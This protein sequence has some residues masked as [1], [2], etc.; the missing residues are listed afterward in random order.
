MY[1]VLD[2]CGFCDIAFA[3]INV[4]RSDLL[5][6]RPSLCSCASPEPRASK[7]YTVAL[8][9]A[10]HMHDVVRRGMC[11]ICQ[12]TRT[13]CSNELLAMLRCMRSS[14]V[15]GAYNLRS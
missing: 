13:R 5:A 12:H 7:V 6:A 11:N 9:R 3:A 15:R 8:N 4:K 1:N 10:M 2:V 14:W